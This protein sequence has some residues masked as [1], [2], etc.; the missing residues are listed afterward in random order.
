MRD[1]IFNIKSYLKEYNYIWKYKLIW[2]LP[3]IIFLASLDWISKAI[4]VKQM[5]LDGA[6]VTFIP[7]FIGFQYVINPG[8]AYGMN[9]GNLSLAISIAALVTL[10]L[11]GV[12]I[13]IKNKYWLIPIN[14]MVAGSVANLLGRAWAPATNKGIKGGV[15]DFLKFEFSFFGSDSYIFNLADAWVSIAVGIII[16]ILIVYV[17]L[18]IIELVMRKK[19]KDK[20]E[21][22]CDIQNRKQILFEVYYQKF[23]FKKEEKM[24][25]KQYLKSNQELSKTWKEYKQKG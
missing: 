9:A 4:V 11:I 24:T 19:D 6:G 25:Y 7:N 18:E 23:N 1:F 10:F 3:L 12:F 8:A 15:V 13:F 21:F 17:I 20:Y 22:Y 2:C 16:L 5:V 14:L